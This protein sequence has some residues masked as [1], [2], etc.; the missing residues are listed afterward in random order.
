MCTFGLESITT[1]GLSAFPQVLNSQDFEEYPLKPLDH[2]QARDS[3]ITSTQDQPGTSGLESLHHD[4]EMELGLGAGAGILSGPGVNQSSDLG[5]EFGY[6]AEE[7]SSLGAGLDFASGVGASAGGDLTSA[8][9]E[10]QRR[11]SLQDTQM[12]LDSRT[13]EEH[14]SDPGGS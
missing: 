4:L 12:L 5:L 1:D 8:D 13:P 7:E 14:S 3:V 9:P 10:I 11:G 2:T 6:G